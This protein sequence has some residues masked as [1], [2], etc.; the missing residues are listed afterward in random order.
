MAAVVEAIARDLEGKLKVVIVNVED[1]PGAAVRHGVMRV[2]G[3]LVVKA[4]QVIARASGVHSQESLLD[5]LAPA[6]E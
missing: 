2:P 1:A 3:F 5:A 6:L 4:G